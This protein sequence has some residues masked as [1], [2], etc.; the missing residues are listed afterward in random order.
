MA[1][2]DSAYNKARDIL[3]HAGSCSASKSHVKHTNGSNS[4][5]DHGKD[6]LREA[7]DEFRNMDK[8]KK[9]LKSEMT[10]DHHKAIKSAADA[11]GLT[12]W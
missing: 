8:G 4:P 3:I 11:M 1:I 12:S 10:Q 2:K 9:D 7:R 5:D 6:L